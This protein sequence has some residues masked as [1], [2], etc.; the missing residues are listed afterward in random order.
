[1]RFHV[2]QRSFAKTGWGQIEGTLNKRR[3]QQLTVRKGGEKDWFGWSS[4]QFWFVT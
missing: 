3:F 4:D 1:M 2:K